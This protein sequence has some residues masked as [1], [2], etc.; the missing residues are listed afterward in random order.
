MKYTAFTILVFL[1]ALSPAEGRVLSEKTSPRERFLSRKDLIYYGTY[2][3]ISALVYKHTWA[4]FPDFGEECTAYIHVGG[5]I[6]NLL[7]SEGTI[8][9]ETS[10]ASKSALCDIMRTGEYK[11]LIAAE[12]F[13][14]DYYTFGDIFGDV[15]NLITIGGISTSLLGVSGGTIHFYGCSC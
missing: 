2:H 14:L 4:E 9:M 5:A 10:R 6:L 8:Y 13:A 11:P 15:S 1:A 3:S 12:A 7:Y